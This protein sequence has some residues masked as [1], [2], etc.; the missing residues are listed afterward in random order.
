MATELGVGYISILPEVSKISPGIAKALKGV[1]AEAARSGDSMGKKLAD[2]ITSSAGKTLKVG[3]G[4]AGV[5]AG[6][7]IGTGIAKGM[8]RLTAID[9]AQAKMAGLKLG[10]DDIAR[11]MEG[12]N[13]AVKGT[14][15][16][17]DEAAGSA[18]KFLSSNVAVG[19]DLDR[20]LNL[21]ADIAA[22]AGTG[23][24]DISSIL[25][26]IT[27]AGK[28]TGET[29]EQLSDRATGVSGALSKHL[30]V[31]INEVREQISAGKV[32]FETFATAM[33]EHLGGAAQK[34]GDTIKGAFK[35]VGAALGRT[36][37]TVF[38]PFTNNAVEAFKAAG[39][40]VDAFNAK[41]KPLA[42]N[43]S[44]FMDS[45]AM[46]AFRE[47]QLNAEAAFRSVGAFVDN[48]AIPALR[49]FGDTVK[50]V[51]EAFDS[52]GVFE[53]TQRAVLQVKDAFVAVAPAVENVV[54]AVSSAGVHLA[55]AS[56]QILAGAVET[57]ANALEAVSPVLIKVTDFL[58]EH[59][60][61]VAAAVTAWGGMKVVN[62]IS[63]SMS[64]KFVGL[65]QGLKE[66]T[67]QT[68]VMYDVIRNANPEM[69]RFG[70]AVDA[71]K[72]SARDAGG[73]MGLL[74]GAASGVLGIFGGPLGLAVTGVT[75]A[76]VTY[77]N[78]QQNVNLAHDRMEQ[79]TKKA[80]TA[81]ISLAKALS[82][83]TGELVG[84]GLIAAIDLADAKLTDFFE[85]GSLNKDWKTKI[86][87]GD[88]EYFEE[89][90]KRIQESAKYT[91][92][93][94]AEQ[95][96][97]AQKWTEEQYKATEKVIE[98][99]GLTQDEVNE[100][101]AKGGKEYENFMSQLK[102]S[103]EYGALAAEKFEKV[104]NEIEQSAEIA[105]QTPKAFTDVSDALRTIGDESS[106]ASD[107]MK[108]FD[109]VLQSITGADVNAEQLKRE[110]AEY[111]RSLEEQGQKVQE[112]VA[113]NGE[114]VSNIWIGSFEEGSRELDY[115]GSEMAGKVA[116]AFNKVRDD[117]S[118]ALAT[119]MDAEQAQ[120]MA[121]ETLNTIQNQFQLSMEE[122][123]FLENLF[124]V[125]DV[126]ITIPL[127]A[128]L[129]KADSVEQALT[130]MKLEA[131]E[132]VGENPINL[133]FSALDDEEF[134]QL[135]SQLSQNF[136]NI[137]ADADSKR[138]TIKATA[139]EARETMGNFAYELSTYRETL[140]PVSVDVK[141][142][143][144]EFITEL[145][146]TKEQFNEFITQATEETQQE[147]EAKLGANIEE[148]VSQKT[149][150]EEQIAAF[151][152]LNAEVAFGA[153][154]DNVQQEA[155]K[156]K[157]ATDSVPEEKSTTIK[158]DASQAQQAASDI[159]K[160]IQSIPNNVNV[161]FNIN[162]VD[163]AHNALKQI[164]SSLNALN[165][166]EAVARL[167]LNKSAFDNAASNARKT[168]SELDNVR[169]E[170]EAD[171]NIKPLK[172]GDRSARELLKQL[173]SLKASPGVRIDDS[174]VLSD[175]NR[176][177]NQIK[178]V[179]SQTIKVGVEPVAG[180][181]LF[182][183]GKLG[184]LATGGKITNPG[185]R[186]PSHGP[187]T[188]KVDGFTAFNDHGQPIA[189]LNR[190][191]WVINRRS[192]DKYDKVLKSINAGT[193]AI[194]DPAQA[195]GASLQGYARGGRAKK[196]PAEIYAF[197]SGKTGLTPG[198]L[199][200]S[201]YVW[202]GGLTA[203]WGDCS[204]SVS[205]IGAY[206]V[207]W[208]INGRKFAT[209][210]EGDVLAQMGARPGRGG[211]G[212]GLLYGWFNG[213]PWGGH[214]AATLYWGNGKQTRFEMGGGRGNG[215]IDGAAAHALDPQFTD[216]AWLPLGPSY[217]RFFA[218]G[219]PGPFQQTFK[220]FRNDLPLRYKNQETAIDWADFGVHT[221]AK[222]LM[223]KKGQLL[224]WNQ[225]PKKYDVGG[226]L[227]HG[228]AAHNASGKKE[229][230]LTNAQWAMQTKQLEG[231][232]QLV[233]NTIKAA[234]SI[235]KAFE[236]QRNEKWFYTTAAEDTVTRMVMDRD[237]MRWGEIDKNVIEATNNLQKVY[238]EIEKENEEYS[239]AVLER[240]R[241]HKELVEAQN[242]ELD[243]KYDEKDIPEEK[244]NKKAEA[245][246]K[247]TEDLKKKQDS[248]NKALEKEQSIKK[249][250]L[251]QD[252]RIREAEAKIAEAYYKSISEVS[253]G[254]GT[255][256]SHTFNHISGFLDELS[257]YAG[258]AEKTRQ[259]VAKLQIQQATNYNNSMSALHELRQR[260]RDV[261]T[262]RLMGAVSVIEAEM[263]LE[264]ARDAAAYLGLTGVD[265][266]S[267]AYDVF[268]RT[269]KFAITELTEEQINGA[270]NVKAAEW[271][272]YIARAQAA[273]NL[274]EAT[275]R[276][277]L[278]QQ[279]VAETTLT[280]LHATEMLRLQTQLLEQ[281]TR[282]LHGMTQNQLKGA[283]KGFSGAGKIG[284]GLGKIFGGIAA[285]LAGFAAGGPL[286]ALAGAGL[287]V[288]GIAELTKGSIDVHH[289]KKEMDEAWK[290]MNAGQRTA[291]VGGSILGGALGIA[292]GAGAAHYGAGF[293]TGM[294]DITDKVMDSTVG[295]YTYDL[296]ARL[297]KMNLNTEDALTK[298]N[299]NV[300]LEKL[301]LQMERSTLE[302]D[303]LTK[304]DGLKAD[305]EYGK[306]MKQSYETENERYRD[307]LREA[308]NAFKDNNQEILDI[309]VDN[310]RYLS[311]I[312]DGIQELLKVGDAG[313]SGVLLEMLSVLKDIKSNGAISGEQ[314]MSIRA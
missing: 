134:E 158:A 267:A 118:R 136:E 74:K 279:T 174:K 140:E 223:N 236:S 159:S 146:M 49:K 163:G 306:L 198:S 142:N 90:L 61:L 121:Q 128:R 72:F 10:A 54:K 151:K 203:N 157:D 165:A 170:P 182:N 64:S 79:A 189:R 99:L 164:E 227:P 42:E 93:T 52:R 268:Y 53:N 108:A 125:G 301:R 194:T 293:A 302:L 238:D 70:A 221:T 89:D 155:Q 11:S 232:N 12:V 66:F 208:D 58:S 310:S 1:E 311:S 237:F 50:N 292:G 78:H 309:N 59:P 179:F 281:Q 80:E 264:N 243:V 96:A 154:S 295:A 220:P 92:M 247:R 199:E 219:K 23:M 277:A 110:H 60:K 192:S 241:L 107:K 45:T 280:Q 224:P 117:I 202:G 160:N 287:A 234:D 139:E 209:M 95:M 290:N 147:I 39:G 204:G 185:Y 16:G 20:V 130:A 132:F 217:Y 88:R 212:A 106:S 177:F 71:V 149:L 307:A 228:Y 7:A 13:N 300:E 112:L 38:E 262:T 9:E 144:E 32:D 57:T 286:G 206:A 215:Q 276:Q 30:G 240:E 186:L 294:A 127:A 41:I 296:S 261:H 67:G 171:L 230:I 178:S 303:N 111:L 259:E 284:S 233:N 226:V 17:L 285:G 235:A 249:K 242:S 200:G 278:A 29:L 43:V 18:A 207:G 8:G 51:Y 91:S 19:K 22:Q 98:S 289:N 175:A 101:I 271:G 14:A 176:I 28:L 75:T 193:F 48:Q 27:G 225:L 183:G 129:E 94:V 270:S 15:Y 299:Q 254:V 195:V 82:G 100:I 305:V 81:Q 258:L 312:N 229:L 251:D 167:S 196:S 269:G 222:G 187:G 210:N 24:D 190:D 77:T 252:K 272:V 105:K 26:K 260:E 133:Q 250:S 313:D 274:Q 231:A 63:D 218:T 33:E 143:S 104:R 273:V 115:K 211:G 25:A 180:P 216:H 47:F 263:E 255:A 109:T 214:T 35:N 248:Y 141:M 120:Q 288:S 5:A 239:N 3:L 265:A 21:T 244:A 83:T 148:L 103:G 314:Y 76:L 137:Q 119:G 56:W 201:P 68:G 44:K 181:G 37:A 46:P 172:A 135:R 257:K 246:K 282:E 6:A 283:S 188:S 205:G 162:G 36:G 156:A 102:D 245:E 124:G 113:V 131:D 152:E 69:G 87:T 84:D 150:A 275:Y 55:G 2:G 197:A 161:K 166:K 191:E 4:A 304:M 34:S 123:A 65:S 184:G 116:D 86:F 168:L 213:G 256:L 253:Q 31:S 114:A 153:N 138:I 145:N 308:A 298:L 97:V 169:A 85:K 126:E 122:M 40:A 291:V 297:E 266:L 173:G 62:T 73:A